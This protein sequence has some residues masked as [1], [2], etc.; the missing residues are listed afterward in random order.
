MW[1]KRGEGKMPAAADL[2]SR[3][4]ALAGAGLPQWCLRPLGCLLRRRLF[5]VHPLY[6]RAM[7]P[8]IR[9][10]TRIGREGRVLVLHR[11]GTVITR[12]SLL[13]VEA[14]SGF[15]SGGAA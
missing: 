13:T 12:L 9:G 7:P 2:G 8:K 10:R 5:F 4:R 14:E 3:N 11:R 15:P 6:T 1:Y